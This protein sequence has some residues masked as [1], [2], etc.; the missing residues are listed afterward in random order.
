MKKAYATVELAD[1]NPA[2][3][4]AAFVDCRNAFESAAMFHSDLL[5]A[6]AEWS[7]KHALALQALATAEAQIEEKKKMEFDGEE[8]DVNFWSNNGLGKLRN[9][10]DQLRGT[11]ENPAVAQHLSCA[12]LDGIAASAQL[13]TNDAEAVLGGAYYALGCS[14]QRA[15]VAESLAEAMAKKMGMEP[16]ADGYEG[17]D[18]RAAN[19]IHLKSGTTGFEVVIILTPI[20]E[21]NKCGYNAETHIVNRGSNFN[22]AATFESELADVMKKHGLH[23]TGAIP[24]DAEVVKKVERWEEHTKVKVPAV[25]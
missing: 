13:I 3:A 18:W 8:R 16:V 7:A 10:V 2:F 14:D 1:N 17:N 11:L 4:S 20:L 5:A 24:V 6:E 21:N 23:G 25:I 19:M 9:R 15:G 12:D 22:D